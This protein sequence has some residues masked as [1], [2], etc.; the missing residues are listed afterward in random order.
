MNKLS[1]LRFLRLGRRFN[2]KMMNRLDKS[3]ELGIFDL[4]YELGFDFFKKINEELGLKKV[5]EIIKN[6]D[7]VTE[8]EILDPKLLTQKLK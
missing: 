6:P 3:F 7:S 2:Q 5:I 8:A 1:Y 4:A